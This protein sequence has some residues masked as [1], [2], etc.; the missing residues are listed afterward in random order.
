[1]SI[2]WY[3]EKRKEIELPCI[4]R[5]VRMTVL[6]SKEVILQASFGHELIDQKTALA[7]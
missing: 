1:M 5:E 6:T 2:T 4:T 3:S 7:F